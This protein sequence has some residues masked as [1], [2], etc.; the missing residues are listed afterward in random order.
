MRRATRSASRCASTRSRR[1]SREPAAAPTP[2]DYLLAALGACTSITLWMYAERH[3]WDLG[4]LT[5]TLDFVREDGADRIEREVA[6]T[7]PLDETQRVRLLE[8]CERTPVTAALRAGVAI[9]TRLRSA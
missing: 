7:A 1:T 4:T 8:I 6:C 2:F 3:G 5:V 9:E